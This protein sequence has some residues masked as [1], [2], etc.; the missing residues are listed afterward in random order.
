MIKLIKQLNC[1]HEF[2]Y[3]GSVYHMGE[4]TN[5]QKC[6]KCGKLRIV[7]WK[8]DNHGLYQIDRS[9]GQE[10]WARQN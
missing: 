5:F 6:T 7:K 1:E 9:M 4:T 3:H 10:S 8:G 2:K